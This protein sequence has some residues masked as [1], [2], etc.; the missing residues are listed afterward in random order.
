MSS[1][2][3]RKLYCEKLWTG[4]LP[5]SVTYP[6][7]PTRGLTS[8]VAAKLLRSVSSDRHRR[9]VNRAGAFAGTGIAVRYPARIGAAKS[10]G[11]SSCCITTPIVAPPPAERRFR[12]CVD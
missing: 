2:L 12:S 3:V 10:G 5:F 6:T 7:F 11:R 9:A 4:R 1:R 8:R